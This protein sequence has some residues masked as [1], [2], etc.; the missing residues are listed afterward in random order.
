MKKTLYILFAIALLISCRDNGTHRTL[1]NAEQLLETDVVA[2][3]SI[4]ESM[5][6]P[7]SKRGQAWYAVLKT[8]ADYKQYKP[9]TSDSLILTATKYYGSHRKSYRSAMAWYSQGCVY[10]ELQNDL[11]AID[12]FLKSKDLFPDTL[13]RYYALA[14]QKLGNIYLERKM[15]EQ[16]EYQLTCCRQNAIRLHNKK[17]AN[18]ATIRLGLCALYSRDYDTADSIFT[19]ILNEEDF[20]SNHKKEALYQMSKIKAIH[21][22]D[23]EGALS[24]IDAYLE[25]A[26][27]DTTSTAIGYSLKADIFY[28][29]DDYDSAYIY[30]KKSM[31]YETEL[32]TKCSNVERLSLLSYLRDNPDDA[33]YYHQLYGVLM[34]SVNHVVLSK[35]I[36]DLQYVHRENLLEESLNDRHRRFLI[37]GVSSILLLIIVILLIYAIFK[38][39]EKKKILTKQKELL[40]EEKELRRSSI[41]MLE[42]KVRELSQ[43][44]IEARKVLI[45]TYKNR[46][47]RCRK[48]FCMSE[49]FKTLSAIKTRT[50]ES[51]MS[52][53]TR[54][55]ILE[56]IKVSYFETISDI[57]AEIPDAKELEIETLLL[58]HLGCSNNQIAYMYSVTPIAVKQRV[59]RFSKRCKLD[60]YMIF[61][62]R[63]DK[64]I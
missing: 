34:D 62:N 29:A 60:F 37:I 32:F 15:V 59:S 35:E 61:Y 57:I 49:E 27:G 1:Q 22:K 52:I 55:S 11:A 7:S 5:T 28:M 63:A 8:Q 16:A 44:D 54:N 6:P 41:Q 3:Y 47:H 9:I 56:E 40:Q 45:D 53:I 31:D 10:S 46:L 33:V 25:K 38:N 19:S 13:I 26:I 20:S 12:A 21:S 51:A 4:L 64:E 58:K 30:Y 48:R 18:Y 24:C 50:G 36:R 43:D 42:S 17:T 14:E 2:A 39:R 23:I